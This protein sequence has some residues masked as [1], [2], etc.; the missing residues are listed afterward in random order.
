MKQISVLVAGGSGFIGSHVVAH[1]ASNGQR[2][3]VPTRHPERASHLKVMPTVEVVLADLHDDATVARLVR[4]VD[5]VVNLVGIL[6]SRPA[7]NGAPYGPDFARAHVELP[8]RLVAACAAQGVGRFV[9]VSALGADASGP[10]MYQR[11]KAAGEAA[12]LSEPSVATTIFRP[13]VVF[14]EDDNFLNLFAS[15]QKRFPVMPL[16]GA[17]ARFQPVYVQDV[18]RAIVTALNDTRLAGRVI[19]LAGP[20]VYTLRELVELAGRCSGHPRPVIPL[21][22]GLGRLQAWFMEHL[23]GGPL[24]SRDNLDSMK[25][26]NVASGPIAPE[27]NLALV[28]LEAIAPRYLGRR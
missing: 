7:T 10:S 5:A 8:R 13:S 20:K 1:L 17:N 23:P 22:D 2:V 27:L 19:E 16:A 11:S 15:L 14:G 26:D 28:P 21:S 24:M 12:A 3:I 25:V 6:H 18:A 4:K 9:H